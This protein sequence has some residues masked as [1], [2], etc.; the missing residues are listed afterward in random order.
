MPVFT[1]FLQLIDFILVKSQIRLKKFIT[2]TITKED[3]QLEQF[4]FPIFVY[5]CIELVQTGFSVQKIVESVVRV[6]FNFD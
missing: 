2:S 3:D 6:L 1:V 5:L 4:L